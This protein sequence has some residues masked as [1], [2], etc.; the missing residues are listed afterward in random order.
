[1]LSPNGD[2]TATAARPTSVMF[3]CCVACCEGFEEFNT[4]LHY[5]AGTV[6]AKRYTHRQTLNV[7]SGS[8]VV[9]KEDLRLR[10]TGK[11]GIHI[12]S[13]MDESKA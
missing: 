10:K 7:A 2:V 8:L 9:K 11:H 5:V 12:T 3:L 13:A 1:M 4:A 6:L